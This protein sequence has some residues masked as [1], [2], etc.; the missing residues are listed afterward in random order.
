M[1]YLFSSHP[2]IAFLSFFLIKRG[3]VVCQGDY[4]EV[5]KPNTAKCFSW[6]SPD[7]SKKKGERRCAKPL[8]AKLVRPESVSEIEWIANLNSGKTSKGIWLAY[9]SLEGKQYRNFLHAIIRHF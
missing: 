3:V 2:T 1:T 5:N 6:W 8:E 7:N 4:Y 9:N